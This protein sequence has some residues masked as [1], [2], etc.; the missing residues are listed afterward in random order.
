MK[1]HDI[2]PLYYYDFS[3]KETH[4]FIGHRHARFEINAVLSGEMEVTC[5]ES[6]YALSNGK[7]L[8]IPPGNFHRNRIISSGN[9][10]MLVLEFTAT[11]DHSFGPKICELNKK[12]LTLLNLLSMETEENSVVN[13]GEFLSYNENTE[14]LLSVLLNYISKEN[15]IISRPNNEDS[16]VY[17]KAVSFMKDNIDKTLKIQ[18]IAKE[19]NVCATKLKNIFSRYTGMGCSE[20]FGEMKLGVAYEELLLGKSCAAVSDSL[21]FSSQAYFSGKFKRLY[22]TSPSKLKNNSGK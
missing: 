12:E 22:G 18:D 5:N 15:D 3:F 2:K 13:N 16:R 14:L 20:F 17:E 9:A 1:F 11:T 19:C 8:L 21:G 7:L 6:I 4:A 10:R